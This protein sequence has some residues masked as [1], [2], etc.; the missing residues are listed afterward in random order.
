MT[1]MA[2][3][4]R[5]VEAEEL[6]ALGLCNYG[7]FTSMRVEGM[8]VR[9]LGLHLER[10]VRDSQR[11]FGIAVDADRVRG[12]VRA[13]AG[14]AG[15]PAVVRVTVFDSSGGLERPGSAAD[16]DVLV[17]VR[18]APAM[19]SIAPLRVEAVQYQRELP[20]VK[21]VGLFSS[22]YF[23]RAAQLRGFDD[24]LFT[25]AHSRVSEGATWN[26]GFFDG[27]HVI[28]PKADVLTGVTATLVKSVMSGS[29]MSSVDSIVHL[30]Q[31]SETWAAFATNASVGVRTIQSI[32]SVEL[33]DDSPVIRNLQL[34]Y[35]AIPGE[36]L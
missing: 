4:G 14:Q 10:L 35:A 5:P 17:S 1:V 7:H 24:A 2:L 8:K 19:G 32:D 16:L 20:G 27:A 3:N 12:L 22:L 18:E 15:S 33:L 26:V 28:W 25:D 13:T 21:H 6:R 11:L 31:V 29:G 9:G 30:A 36:S 23:R 34:H